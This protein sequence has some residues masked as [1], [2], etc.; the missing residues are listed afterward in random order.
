MQKT[1]Y[2]ALQRLERLNGNNQVKAQQLC[3]SDIA[4][5]IR[6]ERQTTVANMRDEVV[7]KEKEY[8]VAIYS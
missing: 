2:E 6:Y 8:G 4:E 5:R 7:K 1:D 3:R